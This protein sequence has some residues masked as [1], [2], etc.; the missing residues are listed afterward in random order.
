MNGNGASSGRSAAAT[1]ER[2]LD[3]AER[4]FAERGYEGTSLRALADAAEA[5]IAAVNYHF[6][7]KE[8]LLQAVVARAM[9]P[10]NAER[11]RRLASLNTSGG[12]P[13]IEQ[14]VRAFVE[15]GLDLVDH[16]GDRGPAVARFIGRVL[17]DPS[18][19]IRQLFADQVDPV[20]GR[21]LDALR[22]ALPAHDTDTILFGYTTMLGMLA[23]QQAA[24]FTPVRWRLVSGQT[25]AD[26]AAA[27]EEDRERLIAFLTAG[28][29]HGLAR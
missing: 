10:V 26:E 12:H 2:L 14:L 8:G 5:N 1:R 23:L 13:T 20:E 9:T 17:F 29:I 22:L 18:P 25:R 19:R 15:P 11:E 6:R 16:H 3:T 21:Y 4:L 28:L 24:T 27:R 7:S